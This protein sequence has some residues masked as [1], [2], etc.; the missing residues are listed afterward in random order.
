VV[1]QD[2]K[3]VATAGGWCRMIPHVDIDKIP[4]PERRTFEPVSS[5]MRM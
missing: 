1:A 5:V 3:K 2:V 4:S